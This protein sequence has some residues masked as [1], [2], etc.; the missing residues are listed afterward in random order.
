MGQSSMGMGMGMQGS[1]SFPQA[2]SADLRHGVVGQ[3][4]TAGWDI[5]HI[6]LASRVE[7]QLGSL[8]QHAPLGQHGAR[9]HMASGGQM[10]SAGGGMD[11]RMGGILSGGPASQAPI[12][13]GVDE[14]EA[15][16]RKRKRKKRDE[17][18]PLEGDRHHQFRWLKRM[19][20]QN[21]PRSGLFKPVSAPKP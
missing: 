1:A 9:G 5:S 18:E 14:G 7:K 12:G 19:G 2:S 15:V 11:S 4:S 6:G 16:K 13:Q 10:M 21:L 17:G 8:G 20:Q 3:Y